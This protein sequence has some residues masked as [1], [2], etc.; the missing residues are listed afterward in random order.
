MREVGVE[1]TQVTVNDQQRFLRG[2][3]DC[4]VFPLTGHPPVDVESWRR[5]LQT[6]KDYGLNHIRFHSYCPP[7]AAFVAADELGFYLQVECSS[8]ANQGATIGD[9]QPVDAFLYRE[10]ERILAAYGNHPSFILLAYGNEPGGKNQ[11]Q[12]LADWI[13]HFHALDAR[14]LYTGGSGWPKIKE[15]EFFVDVAPRIQG[16]G[17]E[18]KSRINA[19]DPETATDYREYIKRSPVPIISHE[20]GQWCVYPNLKEIEKYTGHL[21]AK[22]FDIFADWI[23]QAGLADQ[24]QQFVIASGELQTLCYKEDI[25]SALRT[26]GMGGFQLLGLSDFSGQ[27]T[28]P[29][30]VLDSFWEPKDYVSAAEFHQFCGPVVP[31]ARLPKRTFTQDESL[32]AKVELAN[33]GPRGLL[34]AQLRWQLLDTSDNSLVAEGTLSGAAPAN[35]LSP[36]GELEVP[37]SSLKQPAKLQLVVTIVG[38]DIENT[39]DVWCYPTAPQAPQPDVYVTTKLDQAAKDRLQAGG[40]VLYI[41]PAEQVKTDQ[42]IGFSSMFWNTAWTERQA[43]HTLGILC[44][45][46]HPAFLNFPTDSHSNWQWWALINGAAAMDLTDSCP[47][48]DPIVQVVPDWTRPRL[49]ALAFEA[50]VGSGRLLV[51]SANLLED[52]ANRPSVRQFRVSL[53]NYMAS[54]KFRPS[55]TLRLDQVESLIAE[56]EPQE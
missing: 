2:T 53:L 9:G 22:N 41:I 5:V 45:P 35:K 27:G 51:T 39:W 46:S 17:Q 38:T 50:Q 30:G 18:L 19:R 12:F 47:D 32:S 40:K 28:A 21:K 56:S 16:W 55:T 29:V 37:L 48:V 3:L 15:N 34:P 44:E 1:G 25:E 7:E 23:E 54:D 36:M 4:C 13:R 26:P 10:G 6:C 49:L 52:Q 8:W 24:A 33:F 14:R 31:L 20:I 42:Q 43:P 11:N